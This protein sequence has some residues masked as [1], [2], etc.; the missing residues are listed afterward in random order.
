MD[1]EASLQ[2]CCHP[3]VAVITLDCWMIPSLHL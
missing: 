3:A 1:S 2:L